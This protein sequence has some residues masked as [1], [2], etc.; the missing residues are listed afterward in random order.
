MIVKKIT[1][2]ED[3]KNFCLKVNLHLP[4]ELALIYCRSKIKFP[5]IIVYGIYEDDMLV[6][7]MTVT[8][9]Y[10]F[11]HPDSPTGRIANISG[12][13]TLPEYRHRGY[14][15][16][17]LQLIISTS[18]AFNVDYLCCDSK[19]DDLYYKQGFILSDDASRLWLPL[20]GD[21]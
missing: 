10:V 14:A 5:S 11:A 7:I 17:L 1:N 2:V 19:A 12:A 8:F 3:L 16:K 4:S 20:K 13:Y 9:Y 18:R 21:K 15:S 6:S